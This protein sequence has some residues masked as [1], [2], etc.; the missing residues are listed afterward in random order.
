MN[1][2]NVRMIGDLS[3]SELAAL[4]EEEIERFI[5]LEI[6]VDGIE[7]VEC[8]RAISL[9]N[10]GIVADDTAYQVCGVVV[11]SIEDAKIIAGLPVMHEQY[12]YTTGYQYKW[13]DP[14]IPVKIEEVHFYKQHDVG[15]VKDILQ[16]NKAKQE[17]Y[18]TQKRTFDKFLTDTGKIRGRVYE[19]VRDAC[20][21]ARQVQLARETFD[22]YMDLASGDRTVAASFFRNTYKDRPELIAAVL[23]VAADQVAQSV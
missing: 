12:D 20:Q 7:P 11:R 21:S 3:Q 2:I 4:T 16:R 1:R 10:A 15:A 8:P 18:E 23:E 9:E 22:K 5:Q 14:T 13:L 19:A 17:E 6:A